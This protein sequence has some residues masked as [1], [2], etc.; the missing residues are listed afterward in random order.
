MHGVMGDDDE[1][2]VEYDGDGYY[3]SDDDEILTD[4][5]DAEFAFLADTPS[6]EE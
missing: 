4:S 3:T 2:M 6:D 1:Y 5:E